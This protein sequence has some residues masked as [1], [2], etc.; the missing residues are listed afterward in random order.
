MKIKTKIVLFSGLFLSGIIGVLV[1]AVFFLEK[2]VL[3]PLGIIGIVLGIVGALVIASRILGRIEKLTTVAKSITT[4][5]FDRV[6]EPRND[7][8]SQLGAELNWIGEK[9][10]E[11]ERLKSDFISSVSHQF[12]SPLT[13]IEGYIDFFIEGID[14]EI[15][16]DKQIKALN[17]MKHNASRLGKLINDVLE[18]AK[19]EA[20]QLEIKMQPLKLGEILKEKAGEFRSLAREKKIEIEVKTEEKMG[21]VLGDRKKLEKVL[22]N[23]LSNALKFNRRKGKV[24]IEAKETGFQARGRGGFVEVSLSD[25]GCGI[26]KTEISM[27]FDKFRRLAPEDE[28]VMEEL[29]GPGLGLA[30][31]KGL[32][33]AQGGKIWVE[34]EL[35]KGSKFMFTL[36]KA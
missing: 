16:K 11:L 5:K 7:E 9:F 23:L 20:G 25:T 15:G 21:Q 35:G 6:I 2:W 32:V 1:G 30:V 13:A 12:K 22:D 17:I 27:I 19:I 8:L 26:S 36:P 29:K 31:A 14:T 24:V 34:S 3:L 10:G 18:L 4:G 28:T 33:E